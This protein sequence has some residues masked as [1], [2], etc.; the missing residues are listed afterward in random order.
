MTATRLTE[1]KLVSGCFVPRS[2]LGLPGSATQGA[3]Q[4]VVKSTFKFPVMFHGVA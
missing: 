4:E 1:V 2:A 3:T